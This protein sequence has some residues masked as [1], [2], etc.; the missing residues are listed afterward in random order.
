MNLPILDPE[1]EILNLADGIV[2]VRPMPRTELDAAWPLFIDRIF[3]SN[4][5][6]SVQVYTN[7]YDDESGSEPD[8]IFVP[9]P[10]HRDVHDQACFPRK[11]LVLIFTCLNDA[12]KYCHE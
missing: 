5:R 2:R 8:I 9:M 4:L 11:T 10:Q 1:I 6:Q 3:E 12:A 7:Y